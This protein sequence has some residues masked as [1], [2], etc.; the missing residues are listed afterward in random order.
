MM[1]WLVMIGM[2]MLVHLV[3]PSSQDW[4]DK[5]VLHYTDKDFDRLGKYPVILHVLVH[6][7]TVPTKIFTY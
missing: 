3:D 2:V 7:S 1:K 5:E 4:M 6:S